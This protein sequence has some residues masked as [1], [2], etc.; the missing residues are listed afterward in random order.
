MKERGDRPLGE[1]AKNDTTATQ[2]KARQCTAVHIKT[3]NTDTD[4]D[5]NKN[6]DP[7]LSLSPASAVAPIALQYSRHRCH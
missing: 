3:T 2:N 1:K 7:S 6:R 5:T 4:T